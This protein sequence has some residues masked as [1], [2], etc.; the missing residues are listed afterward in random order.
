PSDIKPT[1]LTVSGLTGP[2]VEDY[3]I[4]LAEW[5]ENK[6]E[7]NDMKRLIGLIQN[8]VLG[9]I[10]EKLLPQLKGKSTVAEILYYLNKR[11]KPTDQARRQ[12]II[13]NWNKVQKL[14]TDQAISSWLDQ[15]ELVYAEATEMNLPH[16]I[17]PQAQYSFLYSIQRIA[18]AW[19]ELKL[20]TIDDQVSSGEPI[21]DFYDLIEAFRHKQRL[22]AAFHDK[23]T[24]EIGG[25]NSSGVFTSG[26]KS[27]E[28][29]HKGR[30]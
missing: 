24:E 15:W 18:G 3:K 2:E 22:N 13:S 29:V 17:D 6:S 4:R 28:T 27:S 21:L 11:F 20:V 14:P 7:I 10:S 30:D 16:V 9:S 1:A 26:E 19:A 12:E 8:K 25:I 23:S 5:K